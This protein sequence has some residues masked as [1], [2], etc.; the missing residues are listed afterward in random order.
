[1]RT[2]A[3]IN[4]KGG[5]GKTTTAINLAA[6]IAKRG[7]RTLLVDVDPQSHCA[8][9]LAIPENRIDLQ[10]GDAMLAPDD[11][12]VD[13][14]RLLWRI[15]KDLDLAPCTTKLAG[16][17]AARGG[18]ADREDRDLR[19]RSV[20]QRLAPSYDWCLIDCPP[21]IGLLTFNALRAAEE[22]L[23]P[24]ETGYF[25]MRGAAKQV[26]TIRALC[27]RF[28]VSPS[29]RMLPTLH[30]ED[31][32]LSCDVLAQLQQE[33]EEALVPV[34]I[35]DDAHL[36][37]SAALGVPVID[38]APLSRGAADYSA[39]A[40]WLI[41]HAPEQG[42]PGPAAETIAPL[43][44]PP[45]QLPVMV[46][47]PERPWDGDADEPGDQHRAQSPYVPAVAEPPV[48]SPVSRAAELAERTR[49]L[50]ERSGELNRRLPPEAPRHGVVIEVE[51]IEPPAH[52][53]EPA[54]T[55]AQA[56]PAR[57]PTPR[58][59]TTRERAPAQRFGVHCTEDGTWFVQPGGPHTSIC[60]A[61]DHNGWAPL[62]SVLHYNPRKG[63]HE[64]CVAVPPGR[65]RYRLVV[66]GQWM[67]D[68][69]NPISE[70]NP[71]G[72]IN[73]VL[74]VEPRQGRPAANGAAS[75]VMEI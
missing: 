29:Y 72:E 9:G 34:V 41:E 65:Y 66:N 42:E 45:S 10:I 70:P 44:A 13:T 2:I 73:S 32:I 24:V 12:P 55:P 47:A 52:P 63:V 53:A 62:A 57:S 75:P 71:Y 39:L 22:V 18:L 26:Q 35:R 56:A 3:I 4:Q 14:A 21:S 1:V 15:A 60:I 59:S 6:V 46:A 33:F 48:A 31:S 7:L 50:V 51:Q 37:E 67:A 25:A 64:L 74:V 30:N 38:H 17:E 16:L 8:L 19:L 58:R 36:R 68:P 20:L 5:S 27:R 69:Y 23:I 54:L 28:G 40:S 43:G 61:G 49:R 11:R